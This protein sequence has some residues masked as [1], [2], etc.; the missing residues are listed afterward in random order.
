MPELG[1]GE[2]SRTEFVPRLI[3]VLSGEQ[4]IAA[5]AGGSSRWLSHSSVDGGR[6]TLHLWV[7]SRWA[8]GTRRKENEFLPRLVEVWWRLSAKA[9]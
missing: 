3:E 2:A 1:H 5:A 9:C 8:A 7:W 6:G 4:V